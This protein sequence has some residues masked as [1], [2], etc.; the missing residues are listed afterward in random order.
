MA[1]GIRRL[2]VSG[3]M[4]GFGLL[5]FSAVRRACGARLLAPLYHLV[6]DKP[7]PHVRHLFAVRTPGTFS[8]DLDFFLR[9][10][11][12]VTLAQVH[13]HASAGEPLPPRAIFLSF[14]DGMREV[15]DLIAPM[16]SR[17]GVPATFFLNSAF[18]DNRALFYRHT[19][20]LVCEKLEQIPA[21]RL[22]SLREP[23]SALGFD[24]TDHQHLRRSI[25]SINHGERE[26]LDAAAKLME[27]DVGAF[28]RESRPYLDSD[29]VRELLR[30]GFTIGAHSVDHPLYAQLGLSEQLR[31]TRESTAFL[32]E[33]FAITTRDLAFPFVS[34]GV[35]AD[36]FEA[37]YRDERMDALFCLGGVATDDPRNIERFWM[38]P[39]ATTPAATIVKRFCLKRWRPRGAG[40]LRVMSELPMVSILIPCYNAQA[41]VRQSVESALNQTYPHKEVIVVDDGSTDGSLAVLREFGNSIQLET[42]PNRGG[43]AARNRLLALSKGKWL[44]YLDADDYLLPDKIPAPGQVH[45]R[46]PKPRCHLFADHHSTRTQ[47]E[48]MGN[49]DGGEER[50]NR[51]LSR[52]GRIL[53]QLPSAAPR[54]RRRGRRM[55]GI[56]EGL[57]GA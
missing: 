57:P 6:A 54:R 31:Q 28:L 4:A 5:P 33:R 35:G 40:E 39:D 17:H 55:E 10:C 19:A 23:L 24:A 16:L 38:E 12:P 48:G 30:Q 36:F 43:N 53:H 56:A 3:C 15:A 42:G 47:R 45:A 37:A 8:D 1:N 20:S 9:T 29:Q 22:A 27:V 52:L 13:A 34:D 49:P 2:T 44:S 26:R 7:P 18:I 51:Q 11:T 25:L 21:S 46:T 41:W 14:D 50:C 32:T